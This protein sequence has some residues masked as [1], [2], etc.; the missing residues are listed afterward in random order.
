MVGFY[1]SLV[2]PFRLV[3]TEWTVSNK[4]WKY[5]KPLKI[6]LLADT[7]SIYPWMT[8]NH[9][10]K[11]IQKTNDLKPDIVLL[12]GDYV[13]THPFGIQ[14]SPD[15]GVGPYKNIQSKCGVFAILGN[16]DLHGSEGWP[17]ALEK[18]G[19]AILR[20]DVQKI[21]C[22]NQSFWVAGL[23][24]WWYGKPDILKTIKKVTD[25]NPIILMTHN[26]DA[27]PEIPEGV[28]LTVAG[29]THG[30][31]IRLPFYGAIPFV[32]PSD[33]GTRYVYGHVREQG[34]DLVVSGGLGMT[35]LPLRFLMPPEITVVNLINSDIKPE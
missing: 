23:D 30:G 29:H 18:T 4:N 32:V 22:A 27:F 6:V 2:E 19:I 14:L 26:P 35:G 5:Q 20:N 16:H 31:Q 17:E 12:L 24:E 9:L 34:R 7:H 21:E 3:I 15:E 25:N 10:D 1:A 8:K 13:A 11:I 28:T 33:Y